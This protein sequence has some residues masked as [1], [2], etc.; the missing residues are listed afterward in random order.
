MGKS[1]EVTRAT[2]SANAAISGSYASGLD[3]VPR[4]M[5]VRVHEGEAILTKEQNRERAEGTSGGTLTIEVPLYING[6]KVARAIAKDVD[7]EMG[8]LR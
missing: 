6:K 8:K 1:N 4:D 3:Y 5:N 7:Q 2:G